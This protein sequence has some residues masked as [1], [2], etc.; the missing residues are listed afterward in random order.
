MSILVKCPSCQRVTKVPDSY[1][2]KQGKCPKCGTV[3]RVSSGNADSQST[4]PARTPRTAKGGEAKI[5]TPR[6]I[7]KAT[8]LTKP[9]NTPTGRASSPT[10]SVRPVSSPTPVAVGQ[11]QGL[12][13]K[14]KHRK[15][16]Q[17]KQ[18]VVLYAILGV[19]AAVALGVGGYLFAT[20][21]SDT[22]VAKTPKSDH[23]AASS[24]P[25]ADTKKVKKISKGV[26][27]KGK[28][29]AESKGTEQATTATWWDR[30]RKGIVQVE[31]T[32]KGGKT[33][34]SGF[35][36]DHKGWVATSFAGIQDAKSGVVLTAD[37]ATYRVAGTVALDPKHG[38]AILKIAEDVPNGLP[39]RTGFL[40]L[41]GKKKSVAYACLEGAQSPLKQSKGKVLQRIGA[42]KMPDE[43]R[44]KWNPTFSKRATVFLL[45][46][47]H[48]VPAQAAGGP[49]VDAE[50][51]VLGIH[52]FAGDESK[53][54][55]AVD[56][57]HLASLMTFSLDN[58]IAK[59]KGGGAGPG[60]KVAAGAEL[61][62]EPKLDPSFVFKPY[63]VT[64]KSLATLGKECKAMKWTPRN[65]QQYTKFQELARIITEARRRAK[66]PN[67]KADDRELGKAAKAILDELTVVSWN[68]VRQINRLA[69]AGLK[70]DRHGVFLYGRVSCGAH[71]GSRVGGRNSILFHVDGTDT[72]IALPTT[73]PIKRFKKNSRWLILGIHDPSITLGYR[74][75]G[76]KVGKSPVIE[77]KCILSEPPLFVEEDED[78]G[79]L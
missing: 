23:P 41:K 26:P 51:K 50:G 73:L 75:K 29:G 33:T 27:A 38:L 35:L 16:K 67:A 39:L 19:V 60:G 63:P 21:N 14:K 58:K 64:V 79:E 61:G 46:Q 68:R 59:W 71:G 28:K 9:T 49:L 11:P 31:V 42:D 77:A 1:A 53:I 4:P 78:M 15:R 30:V 74:I 48:P 56:V 57:K 55:Y 6:P 2:G 66:G 76:G 25:Q 8:P 7:S 32:K 44:T 18:P 5:P 17:P 45:E 34:V 24:N 43:V 40:P 20:S 72:K 52:L 62:S 37:G 36:L 70:T 69:I 10:A 13:V 12:G 47:S 54:G 22:K 3:F 65:A